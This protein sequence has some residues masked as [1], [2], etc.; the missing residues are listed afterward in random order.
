[1]LDTT[2]RVRDLAYQLWEQEGRP[3]GRERDHWLEA[4]RLLSAKEPAKP[5]RAKSKEK[6]RIPSGRK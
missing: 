1:M 5:R 4:E 6:Q 2:D 3:A